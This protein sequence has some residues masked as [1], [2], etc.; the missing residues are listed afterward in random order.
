MFHFPVRSSDFEYF[1]CALVPVVHDF[2]TFLSWF[3]DGFSV[4]LEL[5]QACTQ[6][7]LLVVITVH[8]GQH[9]FSLGVLGYC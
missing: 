3:K 1:I 4:L 6:E 9:N 8:V 2:F 5:L 7:V